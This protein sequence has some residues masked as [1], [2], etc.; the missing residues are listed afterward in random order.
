MRWLDPET[1]GGGTFVLAGGTGELGAADGG[2]FVLLASDSQSGSSLGYL[3]EGGLGPVS[4]GKETSLNLQ[5][6]QTASTAL[7]FVGVGDYAG[8]FGGYSNSN[9]PIQ[10]GAFAEAFGRGGGSYVNIV[11]G[12]GCH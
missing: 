2:G 9:S 10:L 1:C 12:G 4:A 8:I 3:V 11:P 5:T 6:G 7:L